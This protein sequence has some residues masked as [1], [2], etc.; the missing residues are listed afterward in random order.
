MVAAIVGVCGSRFA[1]SLLMIAIQ[2]AGPCGS[3]FGNQEMICN[4]FKI[5]RRSLFADVSKDR[6]NI[7]MNQ[8]R[9]LPDQCGARE[10]RRGFANTLGLFVNEP[11]K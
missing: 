4:P 2:V 1:V 3:V 6:A 11:K 10:V 8:V 5:A 9:S 7:D